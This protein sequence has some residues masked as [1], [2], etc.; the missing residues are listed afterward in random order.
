M[1]AP[2]QQPP[3]ASVW[4]QHVGLALEL[5]PEPANTA[6]AVC[7]E[8]VPEPIAQL[9]LSR[10]VPECV[11]EAARSG[12][13]CTVV[14]EPG[15]ATAWVPRRALPRDAALAE[16]DGV[17]EVEPGKGWCAI[18]IG[19]PGSGRSGLKVPAAPGSAGA[20]CGLLAEAKIEAR[21]MSAFNA[22]VLL[23]RDKALSRLASALVGGGHAVWPASVVMD[24]V[25]WEESEAPKP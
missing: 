2:T 14:Q 1:P 17:D 8:A 25:R 22:E 23:V 21:L 13:F 18:R 10:G 5:I 3:G 16:E 4:Q 7:L 15:A 6:G 11:R 12:S 24:S 20:L 9:R 19:R